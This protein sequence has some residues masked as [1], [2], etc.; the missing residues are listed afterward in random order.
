MRFTAGD[1][2]GVYE[3]VSLL[4]A[5]GMGEVYRAVDTRLHRVVAVKLLADVGA[6]AEARRRF[7]NE[8]RTASALN[9]PNIVTIYDIVDT[10]A[11]AMIVMEF[12]DGRTLAE[13][14]PH[15]GMQPRDALACA[16]QIADGLARAHRAGIVHRDLKPANIMLTADGVVKLLDFGL[17]KFKVAASDQTLSLATQGGTLLGTVGYMSPEQAQGQPL[18]ARTD[19]F[20]FGAVLYEMLTGERAFA[21]ES[22]AAVLG[23]ILRDEPRLLS[24]MA[25]GWTAVVQ[26]CLEKDPDSRVESMDHVKTAIAAL[27]LTAVPRVGPS[28]VVL[29][30]TNLSP[31]KDN[32]YFG[33]GLTEEIIGALSNV[34]GLRVIARASSFR[35]RGETDLAKVG[36]MLSV[37]HTLDGSVRKAGNRVRIS[38]QLTR[39]ADE[40][41]VW[42]ER[43][44]RDMTDIFAIQ[45][46]IA[47]AV[48]KSLE[49]RLMTSPPVNRPDVTAYTLALRAQQT[50]A[51]RGAT[52]RGSDSHRSH[53]RRGLC[54]ARIVP[55]VSG[56]SRPSGFQGRA[57]AVS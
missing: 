50:P 34:T 55:D 17:A 36:R 5:G 53:L 29:P 20:S 47:G 18:D 31:D 14:I 25:S 56:D 7:A 27:G 11:G 40:T 2:L 9:H 45:D 1:R 16:T 26:R 44:D 42:T 57:D 24:G 46:E 12:V 13:T 51:R 38:V 48:V 10:D 22:T 19:I 32:E 30:L 37:A 21:G 39:I 49:A 35:L 23:A 4:G 43:F 15:G 54:R 3:V 28:I 8:A 41:P 52:L 6:S 33:D